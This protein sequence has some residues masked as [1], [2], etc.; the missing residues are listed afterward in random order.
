MLF[1][2]ATVHT[3]FRRFNDYET[4]M[5]GGRRRSVEGP[6]AFDASTP[7]VARGGD[8]AGVRRYERTKNQAYPAPHT[9]VELANSA[10][11]SSRLAVRRGVEVRAGTNTASLA[12]RLG[13]HPSQ[14]DYGAADF[15][16]SNRARVGSTVDG[17]ADYGAT[18]LGRSTVGST[19]D[20]LATI[21]RPPVQPGGLADRFANVSFSLPHRVLIN[22][23]VVT[24]KE[25]ASLEA[26]AAT[27]S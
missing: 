21:S 15:G 26:N 13:P 27:M 23:T 1:H 18:D 16:P 14:A 5:L 12:S 7:V 19:V 17:Q 25:A 11:H 2:I 24:L 8:M 6:R 4:L 3:G 22:P 20:S 10:G 9:N